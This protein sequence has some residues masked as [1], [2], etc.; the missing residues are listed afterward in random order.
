MEKMV[1]KNNDG[2]LTRIEL[3]TL[4]I[5]EQEIESTDEKT[6]IAEKSFARGFLIAMELVKSG[7][8]DAPS[9]NFIE[10]LRSRVAK[11]FNFESYE[12]FE[13]V[14][15]KKALGLEDDKNNI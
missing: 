2:I 7:Y 6:I 4:K 5:F 12:E 13:K 1:T 9:E 8:K 3:E 14:D 10:K 15:Y 11:I